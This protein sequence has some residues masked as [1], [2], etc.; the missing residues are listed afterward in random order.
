MPGRL[1][2]AAAAAAVAALWP[3]VLHAQSSREPAQPP[4]D[5]AR[6]ARSIADDK[7]ADGK[8]AD[9]KGVRNFSLVATPI[10]VANPAVGNGL[11]IAALGLYRVGDAPRPWATVLGG[12]YT[13]TKTWGTVIGQKAYL[14]GDRF[15]LTAG[16]GGG[17]F[18]TEF[19]GIGQN[20]G[21]RGVSV[22]IKET[23]K[24]GLI[25][26]L[27]RVAP[28]FYIGPEFRYLDLDISVDL[29]NVRFPDQQLPELDLNSKVSALGLAA[30]F[31]TRD[32][33]FGPTKG[34]YATGTWL[35]ASKR[36]GGAFNFDR[37]EGAVNGYHSLD[38]KSVLA[39]RA[40]LCW[41]GG[42][43]PFYQLCSFGQQSDLRGYQSGQYIDHAMYAMQAEYRR[44]LFWRIG[45][46]AFAGVGEVADSFYDMNTR[47][48]LPAGGVGLRFKASKEYNVNVRIDVAKGKGSE[49]LYVSVGEAF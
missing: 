27:V 22:P 8:Q 9:G 29:A 31:D 41:T 30:E 2:A 48:L 17:V 11:A 1:L 23:G 35:R 13:D 43:A 26:G 38:E 37:F 14:G 28:H 24:G 34:I 10:P 16:L 25:E 40:S 3:A 6:T 49:G 7:Q 39:W 47:D 46:V 21:R 44:H 42:G 36:L 4:K 45:G 33:E 12:L 15:R 5:A 19:F 32:N 20:A 18:N